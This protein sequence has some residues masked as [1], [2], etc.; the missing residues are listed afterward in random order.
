MPVTTTTT[1][2]TTTTPSTPKPTTTEATTTTSTASIA[3]STADP[4][5]SHFDPRME[6]SSY[7]VNK[8]AR[9][10]HNTVGLPKQHRVTLSLRFRRPS[11]AWRR[12]TAKR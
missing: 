11:S 7:K 9:A 2:T 3:P 4:Y 5:F 6:H 1:T 12:F 10:Q 8:Q